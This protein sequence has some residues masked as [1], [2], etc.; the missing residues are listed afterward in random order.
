ME[1]VSQ[2]SVCIRVRTNT[3]RKERTDLVDWRVGVFR[4]RHFGLTQLHSGF[5]T[6]TPIWPNRSEYGDMVLR[7]HRRMEKA[8]T[9]FGVT[10]AST[11]PLRSPPRSRL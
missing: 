10:T 7:R 6:A 2:I 11:R 1:M 8:R 9:A 4:D 3:Y 5:T